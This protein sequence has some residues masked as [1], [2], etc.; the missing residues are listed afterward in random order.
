M[1]KTLLTIVVLIT[2]VVIMAFT[3][4]SGD[5]CSP[6]F[7]SGVPP[8]YC[9]DPAGGNFTCF[10]CHSDAAAIPIAGL[11]TSN[12]PIQGYT[13]NNTYTI[14][15]AIMG[16]GHTRFGF[17]IS[18]QNTLGNFLGTLVTT[19]SET[20][21]VG[22]G[23]I[24]HTSTGTNGSGSKT[25]TFNWTAPAPGTGNVT[26]Y[27]AFN[28]TNADNGT[29]GDTIYT[30]T[31]VIPEIVA[32]IANLSSN[33]Q[34]ISVFPNPFS[35]QTTLQTDNL[36]NNATL[37]VDNCFGQTVAQI[38]NLSGQTI[39]FNRSNLPSGVYFVRLTEENKTI[40]VDKL[41]ITD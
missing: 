10:G 25:W 29:S 38:K 17:E 40:A 37:T 22:T 13:P 12:V 19:S 1:K 7:S 34:K 39:T 3:F 6:L 15:A 31:L 33:E 9:G 35:T 26:F 24:T 8:G 2:T 5:N 11:I 16:A 20:Q 36:L 21:I 4:P 32:G 18:P 30:S 28:V 14:T 27:G 41:V 23:Y